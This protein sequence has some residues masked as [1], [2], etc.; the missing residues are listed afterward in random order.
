[1]NF[2]SSINLQ[3]KITNKFFRDETNKI[4]CI[5]NGRCF[6]SSYGKL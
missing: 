3:S 1:M 6:Y 4:P 5:F 2:G